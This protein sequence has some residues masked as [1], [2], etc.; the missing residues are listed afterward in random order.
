MHKT[1]V[2]FS[3]FSAC[4]LILLVINCAGIPRIAVPS[5][6][7]IDVD[8]ETPVASSGITLSTMKQAI[9]INFRDPTNETNAVH[10]K[11]N[12]NGKII[13]NDNT[14]NPTSWKYYPRAVLDYTYKRDGES[15]L[16]SNVEQIAADG[17]RVF[18]KEQDTKI[19]YFSLLMKDRW[20]ES[21]YTR[22][23]PE[24][25][26]DFKTYYF[27]GRA[28]SEIMKSMTLL[29]KD[30]MFVIMYEKTWFKLEPQIDAK[31]IAVGIIKESNAYNPIYGGEHSG[32]WKSYNGDGIVTFYA[33]G[34]DNKIYWVDELTY[35]QDN[36]FQ[37][38]GAVDHTCKQFS[39]SLEWYAAIFGVHPESSSAQHV[40]YGGGLF[41]I[42]DPP[43]YS[44]VPIWPVVF[45]PPW[46]FAN[47]RSY[48]WEPAFSNASSVFI[49][50]SRENLIAIIDTNEIYTINWSY[51]TLDYSWRARAFPQGS[52]I[53]NGILIDRNVEISV[54]TTNGIYFTTY[55]PVNNLYPAL[56]SPATKVF[57]TNGW[58]KR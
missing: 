21:W 14:A 8:A 29:Y 37:I 16:L 56:T 45:V 50:A 53:S 24:Y 35:Y 30:I 54:D 36:R 42:S 49:T 7:P 48:F 38:L 3:I 55:L 44:R 13:Y 18:I 17:N 27:D 19:L 15:R 2:L 31:S 57:F 58:Q 11:I 5:V 4:P 6:T 34:Q 9:T 39:F 52:I 40:V 46:A 41:S 43:W 32:P 1:H 33:V 20:P 25:P 12:T 23:D 28:D 51:G 22:R 47:R 26:L 10:Y